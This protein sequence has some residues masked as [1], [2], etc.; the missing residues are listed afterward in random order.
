MF[1]IIRPFKEA[2]VGLFRHMAMTLSSI[3]SITVTLLF[4]S[5]FLVV[6]VNIEQ[7]TFGIEETV[8][9]H[10]KIRQTHESQ[11]DLDAI[12]QRINLISGVEQIEFSSK[13]DELDKFIES[14]GDDGSIFESYRGENNP[15]RMAYLVSIEQGQSVEA[16]SNQIRVIEGV[17]AVQFGGVKVLELMDLLVN[18]RNGVYALIAGLGLVALFLIS[19]TIKLSIAT[20]QKEIT[21]MRTVGARNW[22][23][24]IPFIIEGALIGLLGS[25]LPIGMTVTGYVFLYDFLEGEL[26]T[27]MFQ[28]LPPMPLVV[29]LS[30]ILMVVAIVVGSV[31]SYIS[32]AKH[33][34]WK[35]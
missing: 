23:I 34:R 3:S 18:V 19:N 31:G 30:G 35:R 25:L 11:E 20:R 33:L 10:V 2:F 17:E 6:T 32:V 12:Y 9:I 7:F 5:V 22:F 26:F 1:R 27:P 4:V 21:I 14:F 16:I 29:Q 24:R 13:D 15:L 28:M 8:N